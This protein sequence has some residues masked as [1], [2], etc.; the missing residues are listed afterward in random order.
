MRRNREISPDE[1]LSHFNDAFRFDE[2]FFYLQPT[3]PRNMLDMS[4][5]PLGPEAEVPEHLQFLLDLE[6]ARD[7]T[8]AEKRKYIRRLE[9]SIAVVKTRAIAALNQDDFSRAKHYVWRCEDARGEVKHMDRHRLMI[10][11]TK[12]KKAI[13]AR[14]LSD[15]DQAVLKRQREIHIVEGITDAVQ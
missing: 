11:T 7:A 1:V 2:E 14:R 4:M 3:G 6:L 10:F 8:P 12:G 5:A 13:K 9:A 15:A